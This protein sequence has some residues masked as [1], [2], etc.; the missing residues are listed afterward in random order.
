MLSDWLGRTG[1]CE[2]TFSGF[3][4]VVLASLGAGLTCSTIRWLIVDALHHRTG[5]PVPKW[6][7]GQLGR[8]T[9]TFELLIEIHY[10]YYQFY[11]NMIV[12]LGVLWVSDCVARNPFE[13]RWRDSLIAGV[14]IL[15][16]LGSRDAMRKYYERVDRMLRSR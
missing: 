13:V 14:I 1:Q 3:L 15:F 11:G 4:Y 6:N 10:R 9:E 7:L 5:I 12:A 16:Y 8:K 2:P